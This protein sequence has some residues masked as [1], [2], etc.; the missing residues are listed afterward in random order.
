MTKMLLKIN[1]D[2][3]FSYDTDGYIIGISNFCICFGKTYEVK[4]IKEIRRKFNDKKLF[5]SLNKPVYNFE[6]KAYKSVLEK[7]DNI[8]LDG[9][10]VGDVAALTYDLK[11]P[12]ILDQLHL[13]NSSLSVKHYAN[14]S[15]G[16]FVLT[17]DITL[18]EINKIKR[19]NKKSLLFKQV[20]GLPHLSTSVR[21]LISN[22]FEH[23]NKNIND[24]LCIISEDG[25]NEQYYIIEDYFGT[26]ILSKNPINLI[27]ILDFI[28]ADYFIIDGYLLNEYNWVVDAFMNKDASLK[29]KIDTKFNAN[30]GFINQK[31]IYKVK[32]ND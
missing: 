26:H 18:D 8:G 30:E 27:G 24:N 9:I 23:F 1:S 10:I 31:T 3:D 12:V 28:M 6:L 21:N 14:N 13:N 11:T 2:D 5:A 22:Y 7:L 25:K 17:N 16:G 19:E 4:N 32:H 20:F 29:N 15:V